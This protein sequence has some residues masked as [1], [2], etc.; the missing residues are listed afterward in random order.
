VEGSQY[1]DGW[2][3]IFQDLEK[4]GYATLYAE[5]EPLLGAFQLRLKGWNEQPTNHYMRPF[6]LAHRD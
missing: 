2:P 4:S 1:I 3:W 6:W 5:D